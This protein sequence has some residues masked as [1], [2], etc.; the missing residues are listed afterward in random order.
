MIFPLKLTDLTADQYVLTL[1][2]LSVFL[3]IIM[4]IYIGLSSRDNE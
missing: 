3:I 4:L 1:Q 2:L